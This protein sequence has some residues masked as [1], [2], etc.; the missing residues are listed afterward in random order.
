M[1]QNE[2]KLYKT[3]GKIHSF[4][5]TVSTFDEAIRGEIGILVKEG[6][7]D[8]VVVWR[9]N[10]EQEGKCYPYYWIGTVDLTA[11]MQPL[12]K[13]LVG[14]VCAERKP[15]NIFDFNRD[16]A[17]EEK[18]LLKGTDAASVV[19]VPFGINEETEGCLEFVRTGSGA[20]FTEDEAEMCSVISMIAEMYIKEAVPMTERKA[21]GQV[22]LSAK[23]IHKSFVSGGVTTEVLKGVYA[24]VFEGEMLC[25]LGESGCGKSTFLNI[26]GGLLRADSGSLTFMGKDVIGMSEDELTAFRRDYIGYI[27]QSYNLMPNLTAKQ[28]L[29]LIAELV[30]EPMDTNEALELVG[31]REK[32]GNYPSQLSGGQQ[33]RI[34]IAR[35]LVKKP[36]LIFADEPTAALDYKTSIEILTVLEK[37]KKTGATILMVTHNEEITR[38]A[39]RVIRFRDGKTFE[40]VVNPCPAKANELKW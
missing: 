37:V 4:L 35:A 20:L 33:Q 10:R 39:D 24:D 18:E 32:G 26:V 1:Q 16:A 34:S 36:R 31:M 27:F 12:G 22:L 17:P 6:L 29:D 5:S 8:S 11:R 15:A 38:M 3:L 23:D 40:V 21:P 19:C 28:N 9:V 30:S 14:K 25:L 7:A 13:G 2:L